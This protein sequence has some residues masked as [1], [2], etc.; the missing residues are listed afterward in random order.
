MRWILGLALLAVSAGVMW[1]NLD[2]ARAEPNLEKRSNLALDNA[3]AALKYARDAY[4]AGDSQVALTKIG[5]VEESVE[6]GYDALVK[7]GKDPRKSPKWF[8]KAEIAT[9]DLLRSMD[10]FDHE[11]AF[12]D[13]AMLDKVK[14]RVQQIHDNLLTGLMEGKRK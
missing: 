7:T 2:E 10:S 6:F 8:K 5:E 3:V 4:R 9:R 1:A 13:R 14:E 11:M 12:S